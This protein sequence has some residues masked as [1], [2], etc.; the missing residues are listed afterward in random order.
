MEKPPEPTPEMAVPE[1]PAPEK[2]SP[3][4]PADKEKDKERVT[5]TERP[6]RGGS[7]GGSGSGGGGGGRQAR[8][9][10]SLTTA[11]PATSRLPKARLPK[12]KA[13]PPPK[14][15]KKW[16]KEVAGNAAA[17]GGPAGSSSDSESSPGAPSEDGEAPGRPAGVVRGRSWVDSS[18]VERWHQA[19]GTR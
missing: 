18:G 10:R 2:P 5:R 1:P 3:P 14:K 8:P 4:R 6:L 15:R 16:L 13:E 9:E 11:Q 12:V 17:G 19:Q 7:S